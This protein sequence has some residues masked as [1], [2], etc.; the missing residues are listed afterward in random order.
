MKTNVCLPASHNILKMFSLYF[1][2]RNSLWPQKCVYQRRAASWGSEGCTIL[3]WG[4]SQ[5]GIYLESAPGRQL[6]WVHI[7]HEHHMKLSQQS[8]ET[9]SPVAALG[10]PDS[11]WRPD[12]AGSAITITCKTVLP[13]EQ[14]TRAVNICMEEGK[15]G[16]HPFKGESRHLFCDLLSHSVTLFIGLPATLWWILRLC[17]RAFSLPDSQRSIALTRVLSED[18]GFYNNRPCPPIVVCKDH[19]PIHADW[20]QSNPARPEALAPMQ[21]GNDVDQQL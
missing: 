11:S 19:L 20:A 6:E 15:T 8:G 17:S 2:S 1:W 12:P 10:L 5:T 18:F 4:S 13:I 7:A 9:G 3:T 16:L 21:A 14:R